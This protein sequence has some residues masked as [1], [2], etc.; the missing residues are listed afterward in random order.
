VGGG[1][2]FAEHGFILETALKLVL[3]ILPV[4]MN[5]S[6]E[7]DAGILPGDAGEMGIRHVE[8]GLLPVPV[9]IIG[10]AVLVIDLVHGQENALV[11][12]LG[13]VDDL[14]QVLGDIADVHL[15]EQAGGHQPEGE[16]GDPAL[17]FLGPIAA[18]G[19]VFLGSEMDMNVDD[20]IAHAPPS[21]RRICEGR[22]PGS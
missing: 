1:D 10:L 5:R 22:L 19:R 12:A 20:R 18:A 6:A 4:G 21:I 8:V 14:E 15:S 11:D 9:L 7:Q 17:E 16:K 2:P 13:A 3:P